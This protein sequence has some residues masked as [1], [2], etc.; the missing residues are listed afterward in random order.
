M[1]PTSGFALPAI[2]AAATV[3]ALGACDRQASP[4]AASGQPPAADNTARNDRDRNAGS[5]TPENQSENET[6]RRIT[7]DIRKALVGNKSLSTN[8]QNCK[9]ITKDGVVT[10][11]G[12]VASQAEK[13]QIASVATGTSG[14]Q[15]VVNE[16]E[17]K[18]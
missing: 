17:I 8:A 11:R 12:P 6:D 1:R 18:S 4:H 7:A 14:V 13:D 2:V 16:L 5:P 15:S 3:L 9:I 10:L